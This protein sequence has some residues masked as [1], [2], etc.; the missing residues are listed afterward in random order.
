MCRSIRTLFNFDPPAT[1]DEVRGAS[2]QFVRK[3]TGFHR[4]SQA[5]QDAFGR[6]TD[7]VAQV[8]RQ[9]LDSL[10][11]TAPARDRETEG[12]KGRERAAKRF[13]PRPTAGAAG[14]GPPTAPTARA[15]STG[16][17]RPRSA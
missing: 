1:D 11:T 10:V 9:L 5:N 15:G 12:A 3:L 16:P 17:G 7:D 4:P 14:V 2:L 6:A 13:G 8:A